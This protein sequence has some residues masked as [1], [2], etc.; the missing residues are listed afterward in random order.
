MKRLGKTIIICVLLLFAGYKGFAQSYTQQIDTLK[1]KEQK[2]QSAE[3][4]N[5]QNAKGNG[6]NQTGNSYGYQTAKRVRGG[7]PDMTRA[8]GARPPSIVRPS[9]SGIPKGVG[10]PGGAGRKGGR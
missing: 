1:L 2:G 4:E 7:R 6:T 3:N 10:K 9:G 5:G 8:R